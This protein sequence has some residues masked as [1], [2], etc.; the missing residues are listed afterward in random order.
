MGTDVRSGMES[1]LH[2]VLV[3]SGLSDESTTAQYPYQPDRVINSV[4]DLTEH[5][6]DPLRT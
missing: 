3:L 5:V 1:R 6:D 2:T 4:T